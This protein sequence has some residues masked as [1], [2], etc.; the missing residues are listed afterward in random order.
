[1][2]DKKEKTPKIENKI[3]EKSKDKAKDKSHKDVKKE[4]KHIDLKKTHQHIEA[5]PFSIKTILL[6]PVT[7]EK[8]VRQIELENKI[9]FVVNRKATKKEIKEEIEATFSSKVD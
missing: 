1:M 9:A 2:A 7:T 5:K 3:N 8:I 6:E 4:Q